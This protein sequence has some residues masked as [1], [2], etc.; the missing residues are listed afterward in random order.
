MGEWADKA[1]AKVH[2]PDEKMKNV[3]V[4]YS[5]NTSAYYLR[6]ETFPMGTS[7]T[8]N[9][10]STDAFDADMEGKLKYVNG[11]STREAFQTADGIQYWHFKHKHPSSMV[12]WVGCE[13]YDEDLRHWIKKLEKDLKQKGESIDAIVVPLGMGLTENETNLYFLKELKERHPN[14]KVIVHDAYL[15][16]NANEPDVLKTRRAAYPLDQESEVY[17]VDSNV[18]RH[19]DVDNVRADNGKRYAMHPAI[20]YLTC[21]HNFTKNMQINVLREA[22]DMEPVQAKG[23]AR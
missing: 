16:F 18:L 5:H 20:D 2:A 19:G 4:W 10:C 8:P 3:V 7:M 6:D 22:L 1:S 11:A 13:K 17:G 23:A 14:L 9:M 12:D 21:G 15:G